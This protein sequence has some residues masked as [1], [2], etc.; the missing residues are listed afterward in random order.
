[1]LETRRRG[2]WGDFFT[3]SGPAFLVVRQASGGGGGEAQR[4]WRQNSRLTSTDWNETKPGMS[5]YGRKSI[6][7]AKFNLVVL[8]VLEIW[9]HKIS[10]GRRERVVRFRYLPTENM[11]IC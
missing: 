7:D 2:H 4:L 6:P 11:F 9:R 5:H 3:L 1:M 10:F 8:L